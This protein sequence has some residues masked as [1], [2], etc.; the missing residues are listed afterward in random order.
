MALKSTIF[1]ATLQIADMDRGHYQEHS[2][3]IARHPS[4]TDERMMIRLLAFALHADDNLLFTRGLCVDEEAALWRRDLTGSLDHWI[5]VGL[6]D[7]NRL[8]KA[9]GRARQVTLYCYGGRS[10]RIW[11]ERNAEKLR[12]FENLQILNLPAEATGRLANLARRSMEFHCSVQD[13]QICLGDATT[14]LVIEP[15]IFQQG[16]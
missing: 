12:R 8:R 6:P 13:G 9:C 10:A 2:L 16:H 14:S 15:E 4:E 11:W 5:D 3:T 1:K 7:E